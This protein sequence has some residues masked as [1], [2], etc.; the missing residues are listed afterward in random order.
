MDLGEWQAFQRWID[1]PE[2]RV[3][4]P[5]A[6]ALA[7]RIPPVAVRLRRDFTQILNLIKSHTILHQASRERMQR[8]ALLPPLRTM[9]PS[10]ISCEAISDG[11]GATVS[12]TIRETVNAVAKIIEGG[13]PHAQLHTL[14][15]A[16]G[17][18]RS[19]AQRRYAVA[20]N[21]GYL[22]N[23]EKQGKPTLIIIGD[24]LPEDVEILP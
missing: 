1:L 14:A 3:V 8:A 11:V 5:Y 6:K 12:P 20:K 19:T 21:K 17:V 9:G 16:L 2:H 4:I 13:Q 15:V 7:E 22:V 23:I 10:G 18:E 24:P